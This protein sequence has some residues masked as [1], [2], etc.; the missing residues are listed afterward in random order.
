MANSKLQV[1][2]HPNPIKLDIQRLYKTRMANDNK[3][4]YEIVK[5][6]ANLTGVDPSLLFSSAFQE[7]MNQAVN[8]Q[9]TGRFS[10]DDPKY[11]VNG[12]MHYGLDTF[13][14]KYERLKKYLPVGFDFQ[15]SY[16]YNE[17]GE[18][19]ETGNFKNNTDAL[20]AKGAMIRDEMD[21][22][23]DYAKKKNIALDEKA[24]NYFTMASFNGG[25][26]NAKIMIDEY[27]KTGDKNSFI[28]KGLTSRK[29]VHK[30]IAPRMENMPVAKSLMESA[31]I[32][33]NT[34]KYSPILGNNRASLMSILSKGFPENQ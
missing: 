23:S 1:L 9:F 5:N 2:K 11:P 4:V 3:P 14:E 24:L 16:G 17:K 12:F 30:N 28:D 7:G 34:E 13:G 26:G 6:A 8:D 15:E 31:T 32:T 29:G 10:T 22:I 18:D 27:S 25:F 19:V 20:I 21:F 33:P